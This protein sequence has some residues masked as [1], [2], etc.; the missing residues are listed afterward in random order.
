MISWSFFGMNCLLRKPVSCA[1]PHVVAVHGNP[2]L[3]VPDFDLSFLADA[4]VVK[5]APYDALAGL[6]RGVAI[7]HIDNW[8]SLIMVNVFFPFSLFEFLIRSFLLN[9]LDGSIDGSRLDCG[10]IFARTV[11]HGQCVVQF[12]Q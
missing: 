9:R 10:L 3:L 12:R 8:L 1:N 11:P 4:D 7:A 5:G 6:A 2:I